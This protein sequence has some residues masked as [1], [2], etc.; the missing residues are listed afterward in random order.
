[1]KTNSRKISITVTEVELLRLIQACNGRASQVADRLNFPLAKEF[2]ELA[3]N[4]QV[5]MN[6]LANTGGE[7]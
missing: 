3:K 7:L 1:M 6:V 4:L 5:S 2:D